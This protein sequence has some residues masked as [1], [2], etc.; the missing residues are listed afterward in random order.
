MVIWGNAAR[1]KRTET[2]ID[3]QC[4]PCG[5]NPCTYLK[6]Y[7]NVGEEEKDEEIRIY[8]FPRRVTR[9]TDPLCVHD[10]KCDVLTYVTVSA[11]EWK[12]KITTLGINHQNVATNDGRFVGEGLVVKVQDLNET[13]QLQL[14]HDMRSAV[15]DSEFFQ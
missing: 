12:S 3:Q 15:E 6:I 14:E 8:P 2:E 10:E 11:N 9:N 5:L 4:G 7:K 13:D 1:G